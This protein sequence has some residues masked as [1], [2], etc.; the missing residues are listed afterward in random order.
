VA[1]LVLCGTAL[2]PDDG[3]LWIKNM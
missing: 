1:N 2:V 3:P